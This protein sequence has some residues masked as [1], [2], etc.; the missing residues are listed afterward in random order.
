MPGPPGGRVDR[1]GD[2]FRDLSPSELGFLRS[3]TAMNRNLVA[4]AGATMPHLS[5]VDG[6]VAMH[7]E[8]P[9]HGSPIKLRTVIAGTDAVAVDAVAAR[10][11]GFEPAEIGYLHRASVA[12]L[13]PIDLDQIRIVGDPIETVR[14][15][16]VPHS[17]HNVQRHWRRLDE[18]ALQGP[19]FAGTEA[20][21][22]VRR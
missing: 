3:V 14:R 12:G 6:F 20:G 7:R 13:G 15:R 1:P 11:M 8:G 10:V 5:V 21:R 4:L 18:S 9:R 22:A 19:H 16:F 17:N 2:P